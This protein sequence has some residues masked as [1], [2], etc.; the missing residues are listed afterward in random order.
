MYINNDMWTTVLN[1]VGSTHSHGPGDGTKGKQEDDGYQ[2][3]EGGGAAQET[4][5]PKHT[6]VSGDGCIVHCIV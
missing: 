6:A 3:T 2:E 1:P 5:T 4:R